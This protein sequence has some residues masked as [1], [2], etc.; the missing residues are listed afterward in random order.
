M[1]ILA[2]SN[3]NTIDEDSRF[4]LIDDPWIPVTDLKGIN[5]KIGLR[6]LF[7]YSDSF[8]DLTVG[9]LETIAIYRLLICIAQRALNGPKDYNQWHTVPDELKSKALDYLEEWKEKFFLFGDK[10]FLQ[11]K[12]LVSTSK[13]GDPGKTDKLDF[14]LASGNNGTLFDQNA[15]KEG[16]LHENDWLARF[17]LVF[18]LFSPGGTIG[19]AQWNG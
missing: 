2:N 4:S 11:I 5:K 3:G 10:P 12:N 16:R 18:Q 19:T 9:T 14:G 6:E 1:N 7:E 15:T 8:T 13:S 17:L